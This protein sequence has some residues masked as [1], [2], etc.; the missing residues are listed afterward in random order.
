MET[1]NLVVSEKQGS[2]DIKFELFCF[3]DGQQQI[4]VKLTDKQKAII[5]GDLP[6]KVVIQSRL[7]N[8]SDL[9]KIC[10][11]VAS[12]REAGVKSISLYVPYF[13]G[14]RSD[15]KF[16][17]GSNNYLKDV[18]TPVINSL[19]FENVTVLDPHSDVLEACIHNFKKLTNVNFVKLVI[20]Q[21]KQTYSINNINKEIVFVSPDAGAAKKIFKVSSEL[22]FTGDTI[23][24]SKDRGTDGKINKTIVPIKVNSDSL[25]KHYII[26]DDI[27][28]GGATFVAIAEEIKKSVGEGA[29]IFLIVTHGIFSKGFQE[30][31]KHFTGIYCTNSYRDVITDHEYL[32]K[33]EP[34]SE[35]VKQLKAF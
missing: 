10:C 17:E 8:W 20:N 26:I 7:N 32:P 18:I 27:C 9:E 21:H 16:E 33:I 35:I 5:N 28:D 12:L 15:R 31:S 30:L 29:K 1:L 24:C 22:N 13:L 25:D 3:P 6:F 11:A 2:S 34:H 19:G 4:V 23:I 14:S